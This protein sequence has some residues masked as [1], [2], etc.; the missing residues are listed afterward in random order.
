MVFNPDFTQAGSYTVRIIAN[1]T[2]LVD[3]ELVSI[4]VT[5]TDRPPV[6]TPVAP[7]TVAEGGN[8]N[9]R[10]TAA[11]PDG[12]PITLIAQQL[13]P[14]ATFTDSTGGVGH[15]VFNPN[16]TQAGSYTVRIIANSTTLVDTELVS[17]TVTNTDRAPVI[18]PVAPQTVAEGGNLNVRVTAADP[19]G[20]PITL[21]AQQLPL[22]ATFTD[23]TGGVGHL[24]F[25]PD[26]TQ[27]GSYTVRIIANSTTLVDTEL[28]SITVTNTDRAPVITPVAP[29]TVAEGGNLNVRV[30]AADPDG[31]P[32][33]LIAQQLPLNATFTDSTGG[34]GR[35]VFNPDFTQAGSYTVRIIAN[36]TTLVDTEL[37]SITVTNVD[38]PPVFGSI[39]PQS[40]YENSVLNFSVAATDT[41]GNLI[42]LTSGALPANATFTD[43]GGGNGSFHFAPNLTQEGNYS[44]SFYANSGSPSISD[45][46]IVPV[47][48]LHTNAA[49]VLNPI[50]PQ[51]VNENQSLQFRIISSDIDGTFPTLTALN[52]PANAVLT[53]SLNG[54]GLLVF[55][56]N[57][58]QAGTY[59]VI[60]IASDGLLAD[61]ENV[62]ITVNN[63]NRPPV[64]NPIGN[65]SVIESATL[66]FRVS[67]SDPDLQTP[68]LIA[69]NLPINSTFVDS[70]N[71]AGL[72][73]FT[74]GYTQAGTYN[75]L[76][77]ASDGT[78]SDSEMVRITVFDAGNQPPVIDPILPQSIIEGQ[79][80]QFIVRTSDP[81]STIPIVQ[82]FNLP[83]HAVYADSGNGRGLFAFDPDFT[84][85]GNYN[86]L[87]RAFDGSLYDSLWVQITVID[88]GRPPVLNPIGPRTMT[89]GDTL[90][91]VVTSTDPDGTYPRLFAAPLPNHATFA[92]SL[93]GHGLFT[94]TPDFTQSGI[95]TILFR[96]SDG[97]LVDSE[98]V[99]ITVND[100]GNHAPV[101]APIG[102][103]SVNE[104]QLLSIHF[105]ASDIDGTI[106]Q[107]NV[108]NMPANAAFTDSLN[109]RGAFTFAPDYSQSGGH[110]V[111]FIASDGTAADSELVVITVINTDRPPVITPVPAQTVAEGGALRVRI[112][113]SDPDADP[114]TLIAQQ[115]PLNATFVDSTG[116]IGGLVFNPDYTQAG[117]YQ[118]RII[119]NSLTLADTELVNIAVTGSDLPPVITPVPPQTIAEGGTLGVRVTATDPNGDAI[120]LIA[121]QLP[122]N[123]SFVDS[124]GGRGGLVFNP[125][126]TQAG[127][128]TVRIIANSTTLVDTELVSIT[129]TN[130]DR[131]P[132]ITP[133]AP[134]T[135]VE[136][137]NLNV[138]ITAS[139]PDGDLITLIA[140]QLPLNATF[141]DS[142]GGSRPFGFQSRLHPGRVIYS[143]NH[144]QLNYI[145][146]IPS[147]SV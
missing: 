4:T 27:A 70:T 36:S 95:Y 53:D 113:S 48:V 20:D 39:L 116:G 71:G 7:Q 12:D 136:G 133:V 114:I 76:F 17:I 141:T 138:R 104:G 77:I 72:F 2:T 16:Y 90:R 93:N 58:S 82:A 146:L 31:D 100:W 111:L 28:V 9:V 30:T 122:P 11:D 80:L 47:T 63:V 50:G 37:V 61:S 106:P 112:S 131:A 75:I 56:P 23:S 107:L 108:M 126:F 60:F 73:R 129:V 43:L 49:P 132:V 74:P 57:F 26:F 128:Y 102:P 8:L 21:I 68:S 14:N 92:D 139:D 34:V 124:T 29:Q 67:S 147:L 103:R 59:N 143:Q 78:L 1:S 130:T 96:A 110:N 18:T 140:Q 87:F 44:I 115:L 144:S 45:T 65:R 123:A 94:F 35:L 33:T 134:Q 42:T 81:D 105:S 55:N 120:T 40:V 86:V 79:H 127:S 62:A 117:S 6:I 83:L 142:T 22:N 51:S 25:N 119:A 24:V 5:G 85:S 89:E 46:L 101:L 125:D 64:L 10:V 15:L 109:G 145:W 52:L 91:I 19:D 84:Q 32:I 54:R 69:L 38:L 118:V 135:V 66:S 121:Q 3:T 98:Y 137:G 13:P 97:A 41:D 99:Q 88:F